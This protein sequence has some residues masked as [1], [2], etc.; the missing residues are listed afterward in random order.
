[1]RDP[2]FDEFL[3][4]LKYSFAKKLMNFCL[5][6]T[7]DDSWISFENRKRYQISLELS[8]SVEFASCNVLFPPTVEH[9]RVYIRKETISK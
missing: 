5:K 3:N 1:M 6:Q 2:K 8:K 7:K 9:A 4:N